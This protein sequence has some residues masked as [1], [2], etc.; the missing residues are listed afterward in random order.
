MAR[1]RFD[2]RAKA[3]IGTIAI[4][5]A[6]L[7]QFLTQSEIQSGAIWIVVVAVFLSVVTLFLVIFLPRQRQ[8][9]NKPS[10]GHVSISST[11][12]RPY[13]WKNGSNPFEQPNAKLRYQCSLCKQ[14]VTCIPD[15]EQGCKCRN[16][17][18]SGG[19]VRTKER[20]K[21]LVFEL[22]P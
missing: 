12:L 6:I 7:H 5:I 10:A 22:A 17:V 1:P 20:K 14:L 3:I 4:S 21:V 18:C 16:V 11:N 13:V 19:K 9:K 15:R 2:L 8:G